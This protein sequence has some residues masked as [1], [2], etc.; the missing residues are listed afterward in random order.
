MTDEQ[1]KAK[2]I[3]IA[4]EVVKL[5]ASLTDNPFIAQ[6]ALLYAC[7]AGHKALNELIAKSKAEYN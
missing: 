1:F 2:S 6:T 5:V 4:Q 7:D 3:A